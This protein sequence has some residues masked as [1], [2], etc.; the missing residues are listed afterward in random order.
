MN[1][2]AGTLKIIFL[3]CFTFSHNK[4]TWW[5]AIDCTHCFLFI[6]QPN[7]LSKYLLQHLC[8]VLAVALDTCF[9]SNSCRRHFH[10]QH[11]P[12]LCRLKQ[13][14]LLLLH[15]FLG[16]LISSESVMAENKVLWNN[17]SHTDSQNIFHKILAISVN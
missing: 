5:F 15:H 3:N 7:L 6:C 13:S 11:H 2:G 9:F 16:K 8:S 10:P 4:W 17:H 14:A 1:S 12:I